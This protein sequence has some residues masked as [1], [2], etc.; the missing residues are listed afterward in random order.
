M[1]ITFMHRGQLAEA[2]GHWARIALADFTPRRRLHLADK[3]ADWKASLALLKRFAASSGYRNP[4]QL[5]AHAALENFWQWQEAGREAC[6][7]LIYGIDLGMSGEVLR[8]VY[9]ET[10]ALWIDAAAVADH[11]RHS[12]SAL[13]GED[14]AVGPVLS[15][16]GSDYP[17]AVILL[18]LASL[19]AA[20]D[21]VPAVVE[22]V[23]NFDTDRL[24]DYL[25]AGAMELEVVNEELF[26]K[27]PYGAML[28]FFEQLD[29]ALPDPLVPY[30]ETQYAA[31]HRLSPKQ[32]KT[33]G[34]WLGTYA[35]ALEAAAL[36]V[37]YGWDDAAL[38][39]S[40]H[41]PGDLV[42]FARAAMAAGE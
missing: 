15:T 42:D 27:R 9:L 36:S 29:E 20:L 37:L 41:Y 6:R 26:H 25:S 39:A 16:R 2:C 22:Q 4:D 5:Q 28:P 40:P 31:F 12:M 3:R 10:V 21:E 33:G 35:W 1:T 23:L 24:L 17:Y 8:P 13:E 19:L 11:A 32:Q 18:A 34:P 7:L 38:R 14:Y 30:I